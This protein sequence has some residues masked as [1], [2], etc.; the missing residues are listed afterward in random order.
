MGGLEKMEFTRL[1]VKAKERTSTPSWECI[2]VEFLVLVKVRMITRS[3]SEM[4]NKYSPGFQNCK[5]LMRRETVKIYH[6]LQTYM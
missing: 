3:V 5:P 6:A 1:R 2:E 4:L